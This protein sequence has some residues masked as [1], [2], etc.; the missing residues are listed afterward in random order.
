MAKTKKKTKPPKPKNAPMMPVRKDKKVRQENQRTI[1]RRKRIREIIARTRAARAELDKLS[2]G[3]ELGELAH[4]PVMIELDPY[5]A[6]SRYQTTGDKDLDAARA[7]F[8][9]LKKATAEST[10]PLPSPSP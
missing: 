1:A 9:K 4:L 10:S 6:S 3:V 8:E 5:A 2:A 7:R